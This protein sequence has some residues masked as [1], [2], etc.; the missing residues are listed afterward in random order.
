MAMSVACAGDD[1]TSKRAMIEVKE[2]IAFASAEHVL[3]DDV[4][5]D[6]LAVKRT[7]DIAGGLLAHPINRFPR[8]PGNVRCDDDVGE[9]EQAMPDWRRFLLEHIETGA[10]ELTGHQRI[11]QRRF[12]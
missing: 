6:R 2:A 3:I 5:P 8:D 1:R 10:R 4:L 11:V 7:E 12:V 9:F